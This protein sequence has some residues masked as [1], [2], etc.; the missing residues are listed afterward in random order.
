MSHFL[1]SPTIRVKHLRYPGDPRY[2][3]F[4]CERVAKI[5][6]PSPPYCTAVV[7]DFNYNTYGTVEH[8]CEYYN[9]VSPYCTVDEIAKIVYCHLRHCEI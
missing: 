7:K 2:V 9:R 3:I 8:L 5:T 6:I 4:S 1:Y